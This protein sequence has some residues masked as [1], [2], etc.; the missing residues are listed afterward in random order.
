M[1]TWVISLT[2]GL[3]FLAISEYLFQLSDGATNN[4]EENTCTL[5]IAESSVQGINGVGI[6]TAK[7]FNKG[8]V[9]T[10]PDAPSIPVCDPWSLS[11][12]TINHYWWGEGKGTL[13]DMSFE[14]TDYCM[15]FFVQFGSL[16]NYHTL[17]KNI[18]IDADPIPYDDSFIES[19]ANPGAG[20]FTCHGG[21]TILA[22]SYVSA[23]DELF[24]DYGLDYDVENDFKGHWFEHVPRSYD[25]ESAGSIIE[26]NWEKLQ[27]IRAQ[28][29]YPEEV[30]HALNQEFSKLRE[31]GVLENERIAAIMPK[32]KTQLDRI[33]E[34]SGGRMPMLAKALAQEVSLTRR[35]P[36]WLK[37]NARCVDNIVPGPSTLP[38]AGRGAFAQRFIARGEV[39]VPVPLIQIM[40]RDALIKWE[41]VQNEN[42]DWDEVPYG[43]QL[44]L[45]YCFG[46][47]ESSLLL[48]PITNAIL[49]NHCSNR[50]KECGKDGPNAEWHWDTEWDRDTKRWLNMTL[51]EMA[52]VRLHMSII[53]LR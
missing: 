40:D 47:D 17:L 7:S 38:F 31:A 18:M 32:T 2:S 41:E 42:G 12:G 49:V 48:L 53:Y 20:A 24:L 25:F 30:E 39:V 36:E 51:Q 46:H 3:F 6:F 29:Q 4:G 37:E 34:R 8:D 14:S 52:E 10:P 15:D 22:K 9:I 50:T 26:D 21:R 35:S 11:S 45:N 1:A 23:G 5:Y 33:A 28:I 43:Q 27:D 19:T 13:D 44:L 16:P